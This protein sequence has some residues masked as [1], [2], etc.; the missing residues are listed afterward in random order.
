MNATLL[1]AVYL[2]S[3]PLVFSIFIKKLRISEP[4]SLL[5]VNQKRF[6]IWF[7]LD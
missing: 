4:I 1:Q 7:Y 3:K 5:I 6:F 2:V